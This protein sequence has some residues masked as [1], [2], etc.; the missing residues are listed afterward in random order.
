MTGARWR[1]AGQ[2]IVGD[3]PPHPRTDA[4]LVFR[5]DGGVGNRQ[6]ERMAKKRD[7]GEPVGAR[8]HHAGFGE[9]PEIRRPDP[10]SRGSPHGEI[11][12]RHQNEQQRGDGSHPAQFYSAL[13]LRSEGVGRS[14]PRQLG[15]RKSS[16]L[17]HGPQSEGPVA[18]L[19]W[20]L[21]AWRKSKRPRAARPSHL[22]GKRLNSACGAGWRVRTTFLGAVLSLWGLS[23]SRLVGFGIWLPPTY[24]GAR[25]HRLTAV[26]AP[27]FMLDAFFGFATP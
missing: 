27:R 6:P 25:D 11:D 26:S 7:D 18:P 8:P 24:V 10:A 20:N 15:G 3:E 1:R 12:R 9:G 17:C 19:R 2:K 16:R 22:P 23:L 4:P 14:G 21:S 13:G 5:H